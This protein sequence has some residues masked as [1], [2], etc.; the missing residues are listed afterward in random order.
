MNRRDYRLHLDGREAAARGAGISDSP[1][2]GR[3]GS[4]WRGGARSWLDE[5]DKK[6]DGMNLPDIDIS[7]LND[8]QAQGF[9]CAVCGRGG[10]ALEPIPIET[11]QSVCLFVCSECGE[12]KTV[13][14]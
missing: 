1:Y 4:L 2:G 12:S 14:K 9:T 10:V 11:P 13:G 8:D 5:H 6:G 3:D 7:K